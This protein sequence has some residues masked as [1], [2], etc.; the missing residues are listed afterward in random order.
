MKEVRA[1][2]RVFTS[3]E[4]NG[5][6]LHTLFDSGS[7]RSY[8]AESAAASASLEV[9]VLRRAPFEVGLGGERRPIN[10]YCHVEGR[11]SSFDLDLTAYLV[12]SLGV[13][14]KGNDIHLLFGAN[15]MQS[16]H[17]GLDMQG[18]TLDLS[19]FTRDFI[20]F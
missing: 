5:T 7:R 19:H 6:P 10:R 1:I 18:E 4:V 13:D 14:E 16:W 8:I 11:V 15:D 9:R 12:D 3:V 17:I 2:G 20:E